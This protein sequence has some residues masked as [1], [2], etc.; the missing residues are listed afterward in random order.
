M[1]ITDDDLMSLLD[2][3]HASEGDAQR[4]IGEELFARI[5]THFRE[6]IR[7]SLVRKFGSAGVDSSVRYSVMV[8]DFF[9]TVLAR[10]PD[11]FW[12]AQSLRALRSFASRAIAHD[13]LD[14]LRRRR[15]SASMTHD[16]LEELAESRARHFQD[17]H[18]LDLEWV[19]ARLEL[20]D[21][22]SEPWPLRARVIRHRYV[23]GMD[24]DEIAEQVG[25]AKK[26]QIYEIRDAAIDALRDEARG[27]E[28]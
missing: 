20:W 4:A 8:Q 12:R 27:R 26:K 21:Q 28:G 2:R 24:Y 10:R 6:R 16:E 15:R 14:V 1:E 9:T 22:R 18:D 25:I 17:R 5:D 19:L 7:P 23:D 3:Y 11:E 13:I